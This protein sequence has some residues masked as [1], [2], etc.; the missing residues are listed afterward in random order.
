MDRDKCDVAL[1]LPERLEVHI[2][3]HHDELSAEDL[4][5]LAHIES[6]LKRSAN[7]LMRLD[8]QTPAK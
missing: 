7:R 6:R 3:Q 4:F 5:L 8:E 1:C 2:H